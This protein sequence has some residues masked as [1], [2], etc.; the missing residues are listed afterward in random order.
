[1][2]TLLEAVFYNTKQ[3]YFSGEFLRYIIDRMLS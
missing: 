3:Q 1:M 2:Q